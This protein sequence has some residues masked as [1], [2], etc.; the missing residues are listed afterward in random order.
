MMDR[1][2]KLSS[3]LRAAEGWFSEELPCPGCCSGD[4]GSGIVADVKLGIGGGADMKVEKVS[5][6]LMRIVEW[7]YLSIEDGLRY[8]QHFLLPSECNQN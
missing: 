2:G 3:R 8:L 5:V 1:K 4:V 7:R 6:G